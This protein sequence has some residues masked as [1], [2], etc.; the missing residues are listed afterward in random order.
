MYLV[1]WYQEDEYGI[2]Y[3]GDSYE[4]AKANVDEAIELLGS[5]GFRVVIY[6]SIEEQWKV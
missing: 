4:E 6:K 2:L 3:E 1:V 5:D